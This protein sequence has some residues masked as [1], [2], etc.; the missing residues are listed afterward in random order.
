M[1]EKFSEKLYDLKQERILLAGILGFQSY[2]QSDIEGFIN[3]KDFYSVDSV[4]HK[5]I[6]L[7]MKSLIEEAKVVDIALLSHHLKS[8]NITFRDDMN[9]SSWLEGLDLLSQN[10]NEDGLK[11]SAE[12]VKKLSVRRRLSSRGK[13]INSA[14]NNLDPSSSYDDMVSI[15]DNILNEEIDLIE[16]SS[17]KSTNLF[18]IM[19][20]LVMERASDRSIYKNSG[21]MGP[22]TSLNNLCGSLTQGGQITIICAGSGVGKTQ[23][24]THYCMYIAGKHKIPILHLDNGEMSEEEII[25]RM[26]ASYSRVPLHLIESGDW[27]D[28]KECKSQV[29]S[30]LN[31]ISSGDLTYDYYNVGGKNI[32][33]ILSYVKRYYYSKVGRGNKLIINFD[34]IKSSFENAGKFKAEYQVVGEIVDKWKKLIQRDLVFD[35]RP[36]VSLMTSVQANRVG[37]VGNRN[38]ENVVDDESVISMSH[39]VKQY[40]SH[41]LI[42]RN[43][44]IDELQDDPIHLGR[45]VMKIEKARAYGADFARANNLVEM[46]DGSQKRNY[47]NFEFDNFKI[48]DKGD[49]VDMLQNRNEI[50]ELQSNSEAGSEL[51]I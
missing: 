18:D 25:F 24:T 49:L 45:H 36:Q 1:V 17:G 21:P 2:F 30:A 34:Y 29:E 6:F 28:N 9:L 10:I 13:E 19:P 33:E 12:I 11:N 39:R 40:C 23:F 48:I 37:T 22:H 7:K 47:I 32:D 8:L 31:K 44:T 43:K 27:A 3:E 4:A 35:G 41:L 51:P 15:C 26:L 42:L 20:D 46:P 38:S 16:T 50:N 14:M 5:T